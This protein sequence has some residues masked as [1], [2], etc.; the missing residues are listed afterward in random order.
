MTEEA[1]KTKLCEIIISMDEIIHDDKIN[2]IEELELF[3]LSRLIKTFERKSQ[4]LNSYFDIF[5]NESKEQF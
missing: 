3:D 1:K 4:Y 2:T 5:Y